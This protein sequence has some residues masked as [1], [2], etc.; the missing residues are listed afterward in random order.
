MK[1]ILLTTALVAFSA[2]PAL[3]QTATTPAPTTPAPAASA[4]GTTAPLAPN[5]VLFLDETTPDAI[6]ASDF[7]GQ[8]VYVSEAAVGD[9]AMND[10]SADWDDVGD[11]QDVILGR[12]GQVKAILVDVGGFLGVGERRVAVDMGALRLVQDGDSPG[13]YFVVFTANR[14]AIE[15]APQYNVLDADAVSTTPATG[16]VPA[17]GAS[18][19]PPASTAA[20]TERTWGVNPMEGYTRADAAIL[21]ADQLKGAKVYD[22]NNADVG[23]VS[24]LVMS[25]DGKIGQAVIDVGGFLGIGAKPVAIDFSDLDIHK[26]SDGDEYRVFLPHTKEQLKEMPTFQG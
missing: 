11:I 13:D 2:A 26:K 17:P 18:A 6:Y 10:A 22:I 3:A 14:A 1:N 15:N 9:A 12:D 8:S 7:I 21:T 20:T 4:T 5:T 25:A 19:A 24:D 23:S 16:T